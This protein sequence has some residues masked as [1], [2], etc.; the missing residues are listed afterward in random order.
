MF[1][2]VHRT[3]DGGKSW[4]VISPD[5]TT[6]KDE[7]HDIPGGPIQHDHTGVELYTTIFSFEESPLKAG[8][9]WAGS[10]DGL[11]HLSKDNGNSWDNITPKQIPNEGTIN[12]IELS[13]HQDGRAFISVYKYRENDFRPYI[14]MT[15]NYGDNWEL[16]TDGKNGI[17]KNHFVRVIREDPIKKGLLYAGTEFGFYISFDEGKNWMPFQQNL[18]ITPITDMVIK[19]D[20][21]VI[22]TQGRAFWLLDNISLL[23][24][25]SNQVLDKSIHLFK[26]T[27]AYRT[28]LRNP[29]GL[30]APDPAPN[31]AI[32]DFYLKRLPE[33]GDTI[34]IFIKDATNKTRK[35]YSNYPDEENQENKLSLKVGLNRIMWNLSYEEPSIQPKAVFS[36]ANTGGIKAPTGVHTIV[37]S[38]FGKAEQQRLTIKKDPRWSQSD[39]DLYAQYE[40]TDQVKSLLNDCHK[41]IGDLRSARKQLKDLIARVN[42]ADQEAKSEIKTQARRIIDELNTLEKILIQTKSESGQDPINYPPMFDDQIAYLYSVVNAQDD[43]P[44]QGAYDRYNDLLKEWEGYQTRVNTLLNK[45]ILGFNK[46]LR[47]NNVGHI[48][49][50]E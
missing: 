10:D 46:L 24:E 3:K 8:E 20:D 9:L 31:G 34:R 35:V 33:A 17:P 48:L 45:K 36:L 39:E 27:D 5:L 14:F 50:E 13:A 43:R 25:L 28:Q 30:G 11:L 23:R 18:P 22:A 37:L 2:Y 7:Y 32:I 42:I 6:N 4:E 41:A 12:N 1:Q 21:L 40:L 29:R 44:T 38:G 26:P 15:N 47:Q 16:L 19:N 49:V